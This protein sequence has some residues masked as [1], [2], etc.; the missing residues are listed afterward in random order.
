[1]FEPRSER[2]PTSSITTRPC[3]YLQSINFDSI[4]YV[5]ADCRTHQLVKTSKYTSPARHTSAHDGD[6]ILLSQDL[7]FSRGACFARQ[8]MTRQLLN[9]DHENLGEGLRTFS[10]MCTL[11]NFTFQSFSLE[12]C[13]CVFEQWNQFEKIVLCM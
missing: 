10:G 11:S 12:R 4:N 6:G 3:L 13:L 1:M 8:V 7:K 5:Q 2:L 9:Q